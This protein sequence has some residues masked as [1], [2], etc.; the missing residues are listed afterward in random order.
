MILSL[1]LKDNIE[2]NNKMTSL[3][4]SFDESNNYSTEKNDSTIICM[5]TS[6]D[7]IKYYTINNGPFYYYEKFPVKWAKEHPG[8][9]SDEHSGETQLPGPEECMN[10]RY[11]GSVLIN[12]NN[13]TNECCRVFIGY[14]LNCA[15]EFNFQRGLGMEKEGIEKSTREWIECYSKIKMQ[16]NSCENIEIPEDEDEEQFILKNN[17]N[18]F[19]INDKLSMWNT[20]LKDDLI[21]NSIKIKKELEYY[22]LE[23]SDEE[24]SIFLP[25]K[26][27]PL[28]IIDKH[29]KGV[30][31]EYIS[32][33]DDSLC[34]NSNNSVTDISDYLS[35]DEREKEAFDALEYYSD[36]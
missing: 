8:Y 5:Y 20:Y 27:E 15:E 14:C 31:P 19:V 24:D 22:I 23:D 21:M 33:N 3:Y 34:L 17:N 30:F 28:D 35:D 7:N 11:E 18:L 4:N 16:T 10:C 36:F 9:I 32:D 1:L 29:M 2:T 12:I 26:N 25:L 13:E 6:P